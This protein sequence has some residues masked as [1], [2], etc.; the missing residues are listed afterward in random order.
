M[1]GI[2]I[3]Q[4]A[5]VAAS[6]MVNKPVDPYAVVGGNPAKP[7]SDVRRIK[8]KITGESVY[9]WRYYFNTYMPWEDTDFETWYSSLDLNERR[10]HCIEDI[11]E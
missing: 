4:D 5:L 8:N 2:E 6:A 11:K 7:F 9:P 1:P 10:T 3:G